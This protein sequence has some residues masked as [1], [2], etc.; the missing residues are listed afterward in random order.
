[1]VGIIKL[2]RFG[3]LYFALGSQDVLSKKDII[4]YFTTIQAKVTSLKRETA[5]L[6]LIDRQVLSLSPTISYPRREEHLQRAGI[7]P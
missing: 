4:L 6:R 1:M 2:H 5:Y 7:E 3:Q